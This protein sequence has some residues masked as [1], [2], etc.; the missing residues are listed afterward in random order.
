MC[1]YFY[2]F[3]WA[4]ANFVFDSEF[5][6]R[7]IWR[8]TFSHGSTTFKIISRLSSEMYSVHFRV[9]I[10]GYRMESSSNVMTFQRSSMTME[11]KQNWSLEY[12]SRNRIISF[13]L[14]IA[15]RVVFISGWCDVMIRL[16]LCLCVDFLFAS[17]RI[18]I[19]GRTRAC[20]QQ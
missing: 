1:F 15:Y 2:L 16:L 17:L 8:S 11:E 4:Y 19:L 5:F 13:L 9:A 20:I 18:G 7:Y 14:F 10:L 6:F 3:C 12:Q